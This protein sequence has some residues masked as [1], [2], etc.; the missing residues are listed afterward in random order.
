MCRTSL[1]KTFGFVYL[2]PHFEHIGRISHGAGQAASERRAEGIRGQV[3]LTAAVGPPRR[4]PLLQRVVRAEL[5][6]AVRR[7]PEHR[8]PDAGRRE[9]RVR[10]VLL[11]SKVKRDS[12]LP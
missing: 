10:R 1:P 7:L 4:Y 11:T 6:R 3:F 12:K 8:W 5:Y 2:H 9:R